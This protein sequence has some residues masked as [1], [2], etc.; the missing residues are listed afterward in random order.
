MYSA[1]QMQQAVLY[2]DDAVIVVNKP[3][4]LPVHRTPKG[5]ENLEDYF[6]ALRFGA[7]CAP[8][9][10]HRLDKE[11][12]GCLVLGRDRKALARLGHLFQQGRVAKRYL[13][14]VLGGPQEDVGV[15]S[16]PIR[17]FDLGRGKW[18]FR[19]APD[20]QEAITDYAVL[21]RSASYALMAMHPRTGRTHQLR[22]HCQSLGCPILGDAFYGGTCEGVSRL[23]LHAQYVA[24]PYAGSEPVAAS[25][26]LP[27]Y[28][29][30]KISE[31]GWVFPMDNLPF[32]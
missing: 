32:S 25:A 27:M 13:A 7:P 6:D 28:F 18:E 15:V 31:E 5:D 30:E 20:G 3:A 10:A 9:L 21:A 17:R 26:P 24:I 11:T 29:S 16:H 19:M 4:G 8:S 22:L 23:F 2:R 14:L 12:S 1:E